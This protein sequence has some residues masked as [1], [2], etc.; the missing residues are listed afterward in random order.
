MRQSFES[1][2][3]EHFGGTTNM[4]V[5][6]LAAMFVFMSLASLACAD[7]SER[8]NRF[9]FERENRTIVL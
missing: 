7:T 3:I 8:G 5:L 9:V 1:N 6:A 4:I 2:P